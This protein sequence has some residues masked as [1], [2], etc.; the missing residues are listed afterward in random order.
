MMRSVDAVWG[1]ELP[2]DLGAPVIPARPSAVGAARF[3]AMRAPEQL[4]APNPVYVRAPDAVP[5]RR[6]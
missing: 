3:A 4:R 2:A 5:M 1:E 6:S